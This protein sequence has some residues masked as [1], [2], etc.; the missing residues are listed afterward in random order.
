MARYNSRYD[1]RPSFLGYLFRL[2]FMLALV[3]GL[4]F[5]AFA[6][7]GDLSVT[8]QPR[9]LQIDLNRE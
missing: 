7:F 2:L 4:G 1:N 9:T 6:Y 8:P 5:V 3:G